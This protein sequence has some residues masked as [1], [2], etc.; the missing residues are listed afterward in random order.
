MHPVIDP[1][2]IQAIIVAIL[3][4]GVATKIIDITYDRWKQT[5]GRK[6]TRVQ[7]VADLREALARARYLAIKAGVDPDDLP[8]D[9]TDTQTS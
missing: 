9:T 2:M 3:A 5:S 8:D 4:G 7:Q 1:S 6:R